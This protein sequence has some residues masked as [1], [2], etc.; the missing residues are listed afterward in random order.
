MRLA[1]SAIRREIRSGNLTLS[2]PVDLEL[3]ID[4]SVD[5]SLSE[6]FYSLEPAKDL[7]RAGIAGAINLRGYEWPNFIQ[8]FGQ[9]ITVA[10]GHFIDIPV[11]QLILG[12]TNEVVWL[13]QHL[14]GRVEG[15]S[16]IARIG[17]F[18]HISAPTVHPGFHN[19]IMLEFY[20]VGPLPIRVRPGDPICQL[21]LERVDGEGLYQGQFQS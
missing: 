21:I 12:Y 7:E 10:S 11:Q 17:L 18:V 4:S 16:S 1:A 8:Q 5:L 13:P 3:I 15:K 14:G 19:Q 2:P 20:N 9:E 6:R